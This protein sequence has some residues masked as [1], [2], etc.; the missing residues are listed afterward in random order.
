MDGQNP[1]N[2]TNRRK[3]VENPTL[4]GAGGAQAAALGDVMVFDMSSKPAKKTP[5]KKPSAGGRPALNPA[6]ASTKGGAAA[7]QE[8]EILV[9]DKDRQKIEQ[10]H[11]K[12]AKA[13]F[14]HY[15]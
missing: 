12:V 1:A 3:W 4:G 14:D 10:R 13:E 6:F 5:L 15:I 2:N 8:L 9:S 11:S 7:D